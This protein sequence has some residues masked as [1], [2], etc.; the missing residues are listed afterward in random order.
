LKVSAPVIA[1]T[2]QENIIKAIELVKNG[3]LNLLVK[4]LNDELMA[5]ISTKAR[6]HLHLQ[7]DINKLRHSISDHFDIVGH[8]EVIEHFREKL[9]RI[10]SSNSRALFF[11]E[12]GSGKEGAAQYIH[13]TSSRATEPFHVVIAQLPR[14]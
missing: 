1:I 5:E 7:N 8:S 10:A 4:P 11:G 9:K 14:A 3:A 13:Y 12:P 6:K 2:S